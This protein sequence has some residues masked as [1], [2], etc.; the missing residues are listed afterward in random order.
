MQVASSTPNDIPADRADRPP[1]GRPI[2]SIG[3]SD[4]ELARFLELLRRGGATAVADVRSQPFSQRLPQ[5]NRLEL[6]RALREA[7]IAYI[8]LG[9]QLGGRPDRPSLYHAD[10]RVDY[11]RV[12]A[13]PEFQQG[14]DRLCRG[15]ERFAIA[16]LCAEEDPLDCHRGLMIAPALVERGIEP[17]HIRG[18]GSIESMRQ[19]EDRLLRET[20]IGGGMLHGLFATM[21]SPSE[22]GQMLDEAYRTMARKKAFRLRAE[23]AA[24]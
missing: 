20:G 3:H 13:T 5:F 6:E 16:M 21:V 1:A 14:I 10:G 2:L 23:L 9:D 19:M 17:S 12:R 18:D 8:F 11:S 24:E 15:R 7:G 4:H 22:R